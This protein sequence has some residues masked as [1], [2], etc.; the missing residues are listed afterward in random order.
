MRSPGITGL[1]V[2]EL[3]GLRVRS[4][5]ALGRHHHGAAR[6]GSEVDVELSLAAARPVPDVP[7][8]GD[9]VVDFRV[10]GQPVYC[11]AD[12][13][14]V[15]TL[16]V[17]GLCDFEL[18]RSLHR[19]QCRADP[20]ADMGQVALVARGAFLAFWLG[21]QGHSVLHGSAVEVDG[22]GVAFIGGSGAGKSTLAG[23]ACAAG[24]RFVT[25]DLLRLD[26]S[27][28]PRWVGRA[29]ELRLRDG[30]AELVR[31][32]ED[33]WAVATSCDG[34]VA[35]VPP[36]AAGQGGPIAAVVVPNPDRR[37]AAVTVERLGAVDAV[38][39]V[40]SFPRL[41]GWCWAPAQEAQL[42]GA[43]R[44]ADAVPVYLA[45]VPWGPPFDVAVMDDLLDCVT[46][47]PERTGA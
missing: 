14:D 15:L 30:A 44:L 21:R 1:P 36:P 2:Y 18:E 5:L 40:S 4:A 29:P 27:P 41:E 34:R 12:D 6:V 17:H 13:G 46:R 45:T 32:R 35:S 37:A 25:D 22:R 8:P 9:V 20:S 24:A 26:G 3:F 47:A 43:T 39:A 31:G 38:L 42:D 23:W 28:V 16:R 10:E 7:P 33:T 19:A 11:A